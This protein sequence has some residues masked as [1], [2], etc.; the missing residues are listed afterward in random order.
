[1]QVDSYFGC[2]V[3][4][5]VDM[6]WKWSYRA[7]IQNLIIKNIWR[8]RNS[9]LSVELDIGCIGISRWLRWKLVVTF[10]SLNICHMEP[11][12]C[13]KSSW[14]IVKILAKLLFEQQLLCSS[15]TQVFLAKISLRGSTSNASNFVRFREFKYRLLSTDLTADKLFWDKD[16]W[17]KFEMRSSIW[18]LSN[19][20]STKS[21]FVFFD[22]R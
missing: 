13:Q 2:T 11:S 20:F 5:T 12:I 6:H 21:D 17:I 16:K 1:M 7:C 9:L 15:L 10:L 8:L 18:S 3:T 14:W 4:C 19:R 22:F